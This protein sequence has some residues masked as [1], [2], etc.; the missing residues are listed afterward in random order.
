MYL[1]IQKRD[2][3]VHPM[4]VVDTYAKVA[5]DDSGVHSEVLILLTERGVVRP[6]LD[7]LLTRYSERSQ[8]WRRHVVSA[9]KLLIEYM[10]ANQQAFLDPKT[11]FQTFATRLYS[12]TVGDDGLDPSGLYWIP[13]STATVNRHLSAL[14]GLT[15]YLAERQNVEH[16]NPLVTAS[17]HDQRLNYAAWHRRNQNDFLGHIQNKSVSETVR[18]ARNVRGR[19][20]LSR[21]DDDS[22]AFPESLFERFYMEGLGSAQDRR[23]AVRDQLIVIMMHAAGLRESEALHLWVHDVL[24]DPH[25][26]SNAIVRIYHP[27]DGK[28]PED[29]KSRTGKTNRSAYLREKYALTPHNQR[30]S[31]HHVGW[32]NRLVD[33]RD[34]YIQ[35]HWF[36]TDFGRLFL[37]LWCEHLRYLATVE[38]HHPYAFVS[39]EKK[40]IGKP[41]KLSAFNNNY[42][43]ALARIGYTKAKIEGRSPHCHR[44]AYG[45]RMSRAGVDPIMRKKALHHSSLESQVVYTS[46]GI[47]DVTQSLMQATERL[48]KLSQA[49]QVINPFCNWND[50][51]KTG[52]EDIDPHGLLSGTHARLRSR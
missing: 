43:N 24:I 20:S 48:D 45:R 2:N 32:K 28:A 4:A 30:R 49:G 1:T 21:S 38:R 18:K 14:R 15:D 39:Y 37:K 25:N 19:R 8:S 13:A 23:C 6:L 22:I 31:T 29:W 5:I 7:Y 3:G 42:A 35:L 9:T 44:H 51:M 41:Y 26:D 46:P 47:A 12:G 50:L 17:S 16:M 34:N 52:F 33:H 27:E 40:H 36:P 10:E 11:L